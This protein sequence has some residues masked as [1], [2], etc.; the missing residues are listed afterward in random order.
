MWFQGVISCRIK[1]NKFFFLVFLVELQ[2]YFTGFL[3]VYITVLLLKKYLTS[4]IAKNIP[5]GFFCNFMNPLI[6]ERKFSQP[7]MSLS[8]VYLTCINF[9]KFHDDLK[10][11]LEVIRLPSWPENKKFSVKIAFFPHFWPLE[12][13]VFELMTNLKFSF[14][15]SVTGSVHIPPKPAFL[16]KFSN[17]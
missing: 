16:F 7:E 5:H 3:K 1:P 15:E 9:W 6:L 13:C 10:A 14:S 17:F 2:L 11:C 12:K 8:Q 4:K